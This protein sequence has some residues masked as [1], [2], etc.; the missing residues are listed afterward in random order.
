MSVDVS[1][2]SVV[3]LSTL[4]ITG[5]AFAADVAEVVTEVKVDEAAASVPQLTLTVKDDGFALLSKVW[6]VGARIAYLGRSWEGA[7]AST[8]RG[9]DGVVLH[10]FT[11]RSLF[12]RAL[13]TDVKVGARHKV[14]P[15]AFV[16][17]RAKSAGGKAIT[18]A[19]NARAFIGQR[20][21]TRKQTSLDVIADLAGDLGW[22]WCLRDDVLLFGSRYW[23]WQGGP[24]PAQ[25][26]PL[27]YDADGLLDVDLAADADDTANVAEGSLRLARGVL[28]NV[29]PWDRLTLAGFGPYSGTWLVESVEIS[30]DPDEPVRI[31][32]AQPR[33]PT[34]R[35]AATS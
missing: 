32:I 26:W 25:T 22:S 16:A 24:S 27:A 33:K 31:D 29:R 12:G 10:T 6:T 13:R 18:Q 20:G 21:G 17:A 3:D 5:A 14:S 15:S 35:K 28:D 8:R 2:L 23:A 9:E 4:T 1:T 19:S 34:P 30:G 7:G 11:A